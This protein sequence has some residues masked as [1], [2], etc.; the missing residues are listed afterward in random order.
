MR[1]IEQLS[2]DHFYAEMDIRVDLEWG[3]KIRAL[4]CRYCGDTRLPATSQPLPEPVL[5][6]LGLPPPEAR[7]PRAPR[8]E[9]LSFEAAW[10]KMTE[11]HREM[12]DAVLRT[13]APAYR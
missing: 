8:H 4:V 3:Q 13:R 7:S 1:T 5:R 9:Q 6:L 11:F 2:C 10:L 12:A